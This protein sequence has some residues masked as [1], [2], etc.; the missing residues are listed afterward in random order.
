[1]THPPVAPDSGAGSEPGTGTGAGPGAGSGTGTGSSPGS[2]PSASAASA[3]GSTHAA[4]PALLVR[5]LTVELPDGTPVLANLDLTVSGGE[6][7]AIVGA[8]GAGKS[9]L[10]RTLLGLTQERR[11]WNVRSESFTI[12]G[13]E[14]RRASPRR[15]RT[16]RGTAVGLVLQDALQSLDPLR[17][18]AAEVGEALRI[19]GVRGA[20]RSAAVITALAAAGLSD[21]EARLR[22]RSGELSGGMR[23]RAL[24]ASALAANPALI[25]ADE[26]TTALDSA[27]AAHVLASFRRIRDR[28]T[29]LVLISH[30]LS[31]VARV[32]DRI[33][34][35][36]DGRMVESGQAQQLLEHPQHAAT[37]ALVAAIPRGPKPTPAPSTTRGE[38]EPELL[39]LTGAVREF[40]SPSGGTVGLRGVDLSLHRGEA[41]GVVGESGAGKTTLARILAGA[42]ALD[43]GELARVVPS[44]RVR[45]IPQDPFATFDP[46]WR[47]DRILRASLRPG[48]DARPAEL[49]R[50]VGLGPEFLTRRPASL[51]GG[52]RQRIAIARAL[53][54]QPD[55]LVCD[56]PVSALDMA[57]QAG[58]LDLLR[59]LQA[60]EG[61]ALVFVSHDLAAVRT[62]SDRTLIMRD[63]QVVEAG[64]TEHV[65]SAPQHP[66]TRELIAAAG[67]SV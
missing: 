35:L 15:W 14:L 56:E 60:R 18:I 26:P 59:D 34:V 5:G 62:V 46:R 30:D 52:Q 23:Q 65:F 22:Q 3:P 25:V 16:V 29:A 66:F 57:T 27:T 67:H 49:L 41:V 63:G 17:T 36:H 9:V 47:V 39:R 19:R 64:P 61:V 53:A 37:R 58:I 28:G 13:Q 11:R 33:A 10:A 54:A 24:I 4:H 6:C 40:A 7:L 50:R 48:A 42:E 31:A 45:L 20:E 1:M 8:S 44:T 38:A 21:G 32:A 2:G 51:S 12:A 55:V 43:S